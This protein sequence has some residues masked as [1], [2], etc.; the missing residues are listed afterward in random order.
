MNVLLQNVTIIDP[1]S[2]HHDTRT[3]ILIENGNIRQIGKYISPEGITLVKGND[4]YAAPG[5]MDLHAHLRDPGFEYKESLESGAAAAAAGGF[6]AVL[7]M[8]DTFPVVQTKSSV[9]YILKRSQ[10]LPIEIV[11]SGAIS[12]D[13]DGKEMAELYDMHLAGAKAF[14]DGE[15]PVSNSGLLVRVLMYA[16]N[17][18]GKIHVR[19]DDRTIS[20]GGQMHEGPMST[21]LGLKGIPSLSEE[22]MIARNIY[23]AEY[24]GSPIHF[25]AVST[26]RSVEQIRSAK[27]VGLNVTAS[28]NAANLFWTDEM[29][30]DFNT[31][32]K[33]DPPLRSE[34]D[35]LALLEGI[36]DG[37]ID[38]IT[39]GHA[40]ED[41][42]SKVVEFDLAAFGM[43]ALE[44][45]FSVA[46]SSGKLK[47]AHLVRALSLAPRM[48]TGMEIPKIKVGEKANLTVFDPTMK[49]TFTEKDNKSR[50]KNT[51]LPGKELTGKV[52][53]I[54][55]KG[56]WIMHNEIMK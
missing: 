28:V 17:F 39:S 10:I 53:G 35:R 19:C 21:T 8:P 36:I 48:I 1:S 16:N 27:K 37:T 50:S 2:P 49:W 22:L 3:D 6:T 55:C 32:F 5:F 38:C 31:N 30:S 20:H 7:A 4:L 23:L 52:V 34:E 9:E 42:E 15:H 45:A 44:S 18:G 29:L 43:T 12:Q 14:T 26:A 41:V 13:L 56:K 54:F 24:A 33:V 46:N 40:P 47:P 11:P 51:P 25:M